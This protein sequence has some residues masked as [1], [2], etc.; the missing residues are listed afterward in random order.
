MENNV[1][2]YKKIQSFQKIQSVFE[3][4]NYTE[5]PIDWHIIVTDVR[6]STIAVTEGKYK[7]VNMA[8]VLSIISV[9]NALNDESIP[10]V[11]GGDGATLAIPFAS[12]KKALD[13]L[14]ICQQRVLQEFGLQLKF[15]SI[16]YGSLQANGFKIEVAKLEL[17]PGNEIA[18]L[19]GSGLIKAEQQIK[20]TIN[21]QVVKP[22][23]ST[24][25]DFDGLECR[26]NPISSKKGMFLSV[27]IQ[28]IDSNNS[29]VLSSITQK[30]FSIV[31]DQVSM[32][33]DQLPRTWPPTHLMQ[34]LLIKHGRNP[35]TF[36]KYGLICA[37]TFFFS[38]LLKLVKRESKNGASQYL[39]QL[40]ANTDHFK[41][42]GSIKFVIDTTTKEREQ[43]IEVLNQFQNEKK[44]Y[45]GFNESSFAVITCFVRSLTNHI[46]FI[47][48]GNGGYTKASVMLK[49]QKANI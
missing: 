28:P 32:D 14:S 2:F 30:I 42:E 26:W 27:I 31:K 49:S 17:S 9:K 16:Q 44:I 22:L 18:M 47:D 38:I 43:I 25:A 40:I 46:H 4:E 20:S 3:D 11:F 7:E 8:G 13:A 6:N 15:G 23:T 41:V 29:M 33:F 10:F 12:V 45:F 37:F 5:L 36:I 35:I 21:E 1:D 48:G 39:H 34:E 19:R 24:P